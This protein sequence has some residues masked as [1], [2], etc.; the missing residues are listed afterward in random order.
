MRATVMF[1]AGDVRI[2]NVPDPKIIGLKRG[3]KMHRSTSAKFQMRSV[4][5]IAFVLVSL[6]AAVIAS[7]TGKA[8]NV[9]SSNS[10]QA[11]SERNQS[12]KINIRI[13]NK[14]VTATLVD[15]T[16]ARDFISFLPLNLS[17]DDYSG[18]RSSVICQRRS[19]KTVREHIAIRW[20]TSLTGLP[21]TIL[22]FTTSKVVNRYL[23][24]E[25]SPLER[26]MQAQKRSTCRV[27]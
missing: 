17:I 7:G 20:V 25:S 2:E 11:A 21:L 23:R 18:A 24:Q 16:T 5:L 27:R 1:Q 13:A 15:N 26:S 4:L 22:P 12:M 10:E 8:P 3:G 9:A 19:R 6:A 14:L